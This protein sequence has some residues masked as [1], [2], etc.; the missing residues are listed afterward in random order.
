[1]KFISTNWNGV[2]TDIINELKKRD[3][4]E[5]QNLDEADRLILWND[6]LDDSIQAV[7]LA[8]LYGVPSV[9]V[10]HG[11]HGSSLYYPPFNQKI[12]ADK[13]CVWGPRDKENLVQAGQDSKKIV[14][15]ST[16]ALSHL[17]ERI[18]HRGTNV[19]FCPEHW[20]REVPENLKTVKLLRQL[21]GVNVLTKLIEGH[22]PKYYDNPIISHRGDENHLDICAEVLSRTD[23]V[24][25]IIEST[26]E[27][28][29]QALDIP[30][31]LVDEWKPKV[32]RG[33]ERYL[34]YCRPTSTAAKK[35]KFDTLVDT[36]YQQLENPEELKEAR[37]QVCIL[38]GGTNIQNPAEE[39]IKVI[40][41]VKT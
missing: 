20:D 28:M 3:W 13:M 18:K 31:V 34:K 8:K 33:D 27:L 17:K 24:V 22:N 40:E 10:Q 41:N 32:C 38:E 26:F 39:I 11:R 16:M 30:V 2:L 25:S 23:L 4:E 1:M 19:V 7:Q 21:E 29:A 12:I 9:V 6:V 14:V 15:T 5:A 37:R 36:I 35:A